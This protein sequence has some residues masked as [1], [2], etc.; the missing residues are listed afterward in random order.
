MKKHLGASN[1]IEIGISYIDQMHI[2][3]DLITR[4]KLINAISDFVNNSMDYEVASKVFHSY[5]KSTDIIDHMKEICDVAN[6]EGKPICPKHFFENSF[7]GNQIWTHIEDVRL[8]AGIYKFGLNNWNSV[9]QFVGSG[10]TSTQAWRRWA[11]VLNPKISKEAWTNKE[12]KKL[13]ALVNN[14][15]ERNWLKISQLIGNRS[16]IQCRYRYFQIQKHISFNESR[17]CSFPKPTERAQSYKQSFLNSTKKLSKLVYFND[18]N[19]EPRP[20]FNKETH[21]QLENLFQMLS[22]PEI[23][24][25]I[26]HYN[27]SNH[28]NGSFTSF[29]ENERFLTEQRIASDLKV[30]NNL[31]TSNIYCKDQ[32]LLDI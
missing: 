19:Y 25:P 28:E 21:M 17:N 23:R 6:E 27:T 12:D 20:Q 13:I 2:Q 7:C 18:S 24:M 32:S 26:P 30:S 15:G 8:L 4:E 9:A 5:M 16:D 31:R 22:L 10:K 11:R 14:L 3:I 29:K 1:L